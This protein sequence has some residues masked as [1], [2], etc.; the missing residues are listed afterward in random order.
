LVTL[1]RAANCICG[2][3]LVPFLP[4]L[5]AVLER[6]QEIRVD[7]PTRALLLQISPATVDRLLRS[8]RQGHKKRGLGTTKPGSLLKKQIPVRTFADWNETQAGF[9]EVDLV[10][11]C[12]LNTDGEYLNS[13]VLT[14]IHTT[15]TEQVALLNRSQ[16]TVSAAIAQVRLASP[17][18]LLGLPPIWSGAWTRI[19]AP[20]SSMPTYGATANKSGSPSPVRALTS[21][22]T[23]LTSSRRTGPMC[24]SSSVTGATKAPPPSAPWPS[25]ISPCACT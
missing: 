20:S 1:W 2:K 8:G 25:C 9:L 14:D 15:W 6:H 12:G 5:L 16:Q 7:G 11:H 24:A 23:R 18:P 13:L 10:A 21:R 22:M 19:M 4:E 17:F 3:R